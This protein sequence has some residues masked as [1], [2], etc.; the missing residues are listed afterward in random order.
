VAGGTVLATAAPDVRS[1]A[2]TVGPGR[3]TVTVRAVDTKGNVRT[4]SNSVRYVVD[5]DAPV[6]STLDAV[7]RTGTAGTTLPVTAPWAASDPISGICAQQYT[8]EAGSP[9]EFPASAR[10]AADA[11]PAGAFR[12]TVAATD[13]AGNASNVTGT[14]TAVVYQENRLKYSAGWSAAKSGAAH[15]G[16]FRSTASAGA[17]ASAAV[18]AR[19]VAL[20]ASRSV[21]QG[22]VRVYLDGKLVTTV[23][24][25]AAKA[26]PRQVVWTYAWP[27]V[28]NHT[29]KIVNV[30]T[31][32]RPRA[33]VD[34]LLGLS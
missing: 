9:H 31:K 27:T 34:A 14:A 24:L 20:V 18:K 8:G 3:H 21:T 23:D 29:V 2:V 13:C 28:G 16:T 5:P 12:W 7:F 17:S 6:V 19:S 33:N 10:A 1:A 30:G 32:G 15:G 25:Y 26:A 11:V 22:A 4:A